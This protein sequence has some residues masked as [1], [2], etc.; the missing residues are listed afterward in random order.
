[1]SELNQQYDVVVIGAGP[2]G[3]LAASLLTQKGF[4]VL[5][6]EKQHFPRFSI[7]ESLLPQSMVY[8]AEANLAQ[9]VE[10]AADDLAF[11]YKDGA[12]FY[13]KGQYSQ[14]NFEQKFSSG[15]FSTFQVKR[16]DFDQLLATETK[17]Q[18]AQFAFGYTV[19]D[20]KLNDKPI[21]DLNDEDDKIYQV[22]CRFVL[23][24]SG[25]ARVLPR[26][27]DLN[28]PSDF[29]VRSSIFCHIEDRISDKNYDRN[30]I[31]IVTHPENDDVW[32]WL[33]PFTDGTASFGCVA[34]PSFFDQLSAEANPEQLLD[35]CIEQSDHL[36]NL[37]NKSKK[38]TKVN[39]IT[40]YS[41]N[42]KQLYGENYA[43]L[44]NAGEFLDPIFSS[45]VT[46]AFKSASLAANLL[47]KQF[48]GEKTDWQSE[49][50]DPLQQ[51]VSTF[52]TYVE[53]WYQ[54]QFQKII[55][56]QQAPDNIR[57]MICSVLA[58][59]AWDLDNPFVNN[60]K[61]RLNVLEELC[62]S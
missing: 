22:S 33:I 20:I 38:I 50:A 27:L 52:K 37:L 9:T 15:P 42:V 14:F 40:G 54:G 18:G 62:T 48:N 31:L 47:E 56:F 32:Y 17:K 49:F 45:G 24:A 36:A 11:Q 51:G 59:Y 23:D 60:P 21:I 44:G 12:A 61:R 35:L 28:T 34:E 55:N 58:G 2:A 57:E 39:Q 41:A 3:S 6:V 30:K 53:S 19:T 46:I 29:P 26:L 43:L 25:F 5:V 16:A 4:D 1:M 7:G 13:S 8:L 10:K